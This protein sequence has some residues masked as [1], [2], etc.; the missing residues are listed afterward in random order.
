MTLCLI[1]PSGA[2]AKQSFTLPE[3]EVLMDPTAPYGAKRK[4]VANKQVRRPK[5]SLNFIIGSGEQRRAMINGK[6]LLEGDVI[7]GAKVRK[8]APDHVSLVFRGEEIVLYLNKVKQIR[9]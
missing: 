4:A 9:K 6:K 1:L 5:L 2:S 3:G 8:I 7:S